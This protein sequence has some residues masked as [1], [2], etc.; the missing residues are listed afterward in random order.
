MNIF[1]LKT[2]NKFLIIV[3]KLLVAMVIITLVYFFLELME[4]Y[5]K[6]GNSSTLY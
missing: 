5:F 4:K 1:E 3:H 6:K 2:E